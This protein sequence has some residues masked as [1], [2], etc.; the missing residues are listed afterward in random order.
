MGNCLDWAALPW[1]ID[2][3]GVQDTERLIMQLVA[4]RDSNTNRT[5]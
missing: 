3:L 4:L 2:M 5:E 1:V